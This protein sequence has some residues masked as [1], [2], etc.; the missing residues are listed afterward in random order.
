MSSKPAV[1]ATALEDLESRIAFQEDLIHTL[2]ETVVAQAE[3]IRVLQVQIQ[4]VSK[5][6]KSLVDSVED[7]GID[8]G[9]ERPPH[10]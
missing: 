2:N 6:L 10:Y 3:A 1:A 7:Q 5:R 9:D 4:H 8:G